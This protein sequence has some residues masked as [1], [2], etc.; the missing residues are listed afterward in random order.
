MTSTFQKLKRGLGLTA[1][2]LIIVAALFVSIGRL[3]TPVLNAHL[4]DF[5]SWSSRLLHVPVKIAHVEI[6]WD[7]YEPVIAFKNV[8]ILDKE[9]HQPKFA[10]KKIIVNLSIFRSLW[11][12]R[13]LPE[14]IKVSGAHLTL[15]ETKLGQFNIAELKALY[16]KDE[17]TSAATNLND[18]LGWA[19]IQPN[20]AMEDISITFHPHKG[21]TKS[22]NIKKLV[23]SNSAK[24]HQLFGAAVLNQSVSTHVHFNLSWLGD[25]MDYEHAS[26]EVYLY[27][28]GM[29]LTQWIDKISLPNFEIKQGLGSAKIWAT[30]NKNQFQKIHSLFQI[31]NMEIEPLM[32]HQTQ[33]I[34]RLSGH[35]GW[36][37]EGNEQIFSGNDILLDLPN[38]LWPSTNFVVSIAPE[39]TNNY[40]V[41][42]AQIGYLDL[43]DANHFLF[44]SGL[45]QEP[46]KGALNS[47]NPKGEVRNLKIELPKSSNDWMNMVI[48]SQFSKLYFNP[49][50]LPSGQLIPGVANAEGSLSWNGKEGT[51]SLNNVKPVAITFNKYG[52]KALQFDQLTGLIKA[53]K[54]NDGVL[55]LNA[56]KIQALNSDVKATFDGMLTV[57]VKGSPFINASSQFTIL[58]VAR[59]PNY[60]PLEK[61]NPDLAKWLSHA[62]L[63]GQV[64][65]G[66]MI[67]KGL[68]SD[69]PFTK[70]NGIFQV[71]GLVKDLNLK[72]APHWPI[73]E[74]TKGILTFVSNK[75]LADVAS[76]NLLDLP[77]HQIK[78]EIPYIGPLQDEVLNLKGD[79]EADFG[80]AFH[81]LE[82]TPLQKKFGKDLEG[83]QAKG[84]MKLQLALNIPL[85]Q[86][87]TTIVQGETT[88]K[89]A[90]LNFTSWNL[91]LNNLNGKVNF[92]EKTLQTSNLQGNLFDE[93]VT[94]NFSTLQ[95][96]DENVVKASLD[97]QITVADLERW[98]KIS[99]MKYASGKTPYHAELQFAH[100]QE[101]PSQF[102]LL[103][104]LKGISLD[105]PAP[106]GKAREEIKPLQIKLFL[107]PDKPMQAKIDYEKQL[108]A[109]IALENNGHEMKIL[110][111]ELR[112]GGGD[113]TWQTQPG[114][115]IVSHFK[116]LSWEVLQPYYKWVSEQIPAT[117]AKTIK[118]P[119]LIRRVD[120]QSDFANFLGQRLT[121]SNI[122]LSHA[123]DNW[124]FDINSKEIVGQA[125]ISSDFKQ[126]QGNFQRVYLMPNEKNKAKINP[127]DLPALSIS[128]NDVWYGDKLIG[129]LILNAT[130]NKGGMQ[131]KQ[132]QINSPVSNLSATGYWQL[133]NDR[134]NSH[135]DG[136]L[137]TNRLSQMLTVWGMPASNLVAANAS[138][139]FDLN[140]SDA[141]YNLALDTLSGQVSLRLGQGRVINLSGST[142][143]KMGL[144]RLFSIISFQTIPRRLSLDFSDLFQEGYNF[145][146]MAGNF[147]FQKGNAFT[148]NTQLDGP[149][150]RI[151]IAG[152]IGL[153]AKDFGLMIGVTT[154]VSGSLVPAVAVGAGVVNPL[155]GAAT[156][157]VGTALGQATKGRGSYQYQIVGPWDN[158]IWERMV[159]R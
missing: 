10:V 60:I 40:V 92:S 95:K 49:W 118:K 136:M 5:E 42:N 119:N 96:E 73:L 54:R 72:F 104:D 154:H 98:L 70:Q 25:I 82:N 145:D 33:F 81:F 120:L 18:V 11:S 84:P 128:A 138:A 131:I 56:S 23:L 101:Q 125:T 108:S 47:L 55:T 28:E 64:E 121:K 67:V 148:N 62:F 122:S 99:L 52:M 46:W 1:A 20:L 35:V 115:L 137:S 114:L 153:K 9:T 71:T 123:D 48:N 158:P 80:Q 134:Y 106:Y 24:R 61:I 140:W 112:L 4:P 130:P 22:V 58:D 78:L 77:L 66:K 75:M 89:D 132:L 157:L 16:F 97:G 90:S 113:A 105:L 156:W 116:E 86:P 124:V 57:P 103:T 29:S 144:G 2:T 127:N 32:T 83:V 133:I 100:H 79:I 87:E 76:A 53:Q 129:R 146:Y 109:A 39:A 135:F 13:P 150:A 117:S 91:A 31:Y 30:W 59:I 19:F 15:Q 34:S 45:L 143:A 141:P 151:N 51:F 41:K 44:A 8:T 69:F 7:F 63:A 107:H 142:E 21:E 88:L 17:V 85:K 147:R 26:A 139:Y 50:K 74:K 110:N 6:S 94:L 102:V 152:R 126:I 111:G 12:W 43:R 65:S 3:M 36:R 93:P 155:A 14:S 38:H 159:S 37:R 68:L 27:L 149:V